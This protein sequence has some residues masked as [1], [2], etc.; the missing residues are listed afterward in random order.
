MTPANPGDPSP[1]PPDSESQEPVRG[2]G[3]AWGIF[4]WRMLPWGLVVG[5]LIVLTVGMVWAV[6]AKS[7]RL[8]REREADAG[9]YEAP[10][11]NVLVWPVTPQPL[12]DDVDLPGLVRAWESL[13]VQAQV[14]GRVVEILKDEGA[15]V[16]A[17]DVLARIDERDYRASLGR[18]EA[19]LTLARENLR[20]TRELR[21]EGATTQADL[22]AAIANEGQAKAAVDLAALQLERCAITAPFAAIVNDRFIAPGALVSPGT[23]IVELLDIRRVK[24]VVGIPESDVDRVK[25][26]AEVRIRVSALDGRI[27]AGKRVFLS[28]SPT[29]RA[30][31]YELHLAVDNGDGA[32]RPGMFAE[33][34]IVR[35][36]IQDAIV[37]PLFAVVPRGTE[38][39]VF[40][41][42]ADDIARRRKVD[43][44]L[45]KSVGA[46]KLPDLPADEYL[47]TAEIRSGLSAGDRLVVQG[48]DRLEDGRPVRVMREV[49][50]PADLLR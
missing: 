4:L 23:K 22:D 39:Y 19:N 42:D 37:A 5:L 35:Q 27:F 7:A 44:G 8:K 49:G 50:S 38:K 1:S 25:D 48:Q 24:V 12:I 21:Q 10:A 41:A 14:N 6:Q 47:I 32:L 45:L 9:E 29:E 36:R 17:G 43:L 40:V 28:S 26:L 20:R 13:T 33:A 34:R 18:A 2:Y 46:D 3:E 16:A 11:V 15:S 30:Q 31:V